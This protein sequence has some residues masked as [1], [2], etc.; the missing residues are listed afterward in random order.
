[1]E[2]MPS[3]PGNQFLQGKEKITLIDTGTFT[4]GMNRY[5]AL[6]ALTYQENFH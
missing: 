1:M 3:F 4:L 5:C 6:S 2:D